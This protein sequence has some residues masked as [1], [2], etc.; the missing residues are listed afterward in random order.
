MADAPLLVLSDFR[1]I[2]LD[3][4][5]VIAETRLDFSPIRRRFQLPGGVGMLEAAEHM[6]TFRKNALMDAVVDEEMRGASLSVPVPGAFK[7]VGILDRRGIPWCVLSRNCRASIELAA[8]T[9][10]FPLSVDRTFGREAPFVKPDPRAMIMGADSLSVP[11]SQCLAIGDFTFELLGARRAG[12]RCAGVQKSGPWQRLSDVFYPTVVD[13]VA[14]LERDDSFVPWEYHGIAAARGSDALCRNWR[15]SFLVSGVMNS[16][17]WQKLFDLASSGV[18]SFAVETRELEDEEW[19]QSQ[20]L[21][22]F[23]LRRSM[24]D[25]VRF[26][27]A[28]RYPL[29][30]VEPAGSKSGGTRLEEPLDG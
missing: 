11:A 3:W 7:L 5:G 6:D 1:G 10:G 20:I 9:I 26:A 12:M 8:R 19:E 21:P 17:R 15:K 27:L 2:I 14:S 4:D 16:Q 25:A 28:S 23:L 18:G 30:T 22:P 24:L 29:I 13:F